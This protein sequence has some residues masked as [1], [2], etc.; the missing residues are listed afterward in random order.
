MCKITNL[1]EI[2]LTHFL[3]FSLLFML[4]KKARSCHSQNCV[5]NLKTYDIFPQQWHK[6]IVPRGTIIGKA[7]DK[8][9]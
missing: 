6:V 4:H 1:N 2:Q 7:I 5:I 3:M 9:V 8:R